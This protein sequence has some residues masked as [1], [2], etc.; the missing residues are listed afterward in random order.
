MTFFTKIISCLIGLFTLLNYLL[1][2]LGGRYWFML[3]GIFFFYLLPAIIVLILLQASYFIKAI[4]E[5]DYIK[6]KLIYLL[7]SILILTINIVIPSYPLFKIGFRNQMKNVLSQSQFHQ[8]AAVSRSVIQLNDH[9][10]GPGKDFWKKDTH[11]VQWKK[12]LSSTEIDKLDNSYV[13]FVCDSSVNI[14]W[15]GVL[16]HWGIKIYDKISPVN[17]NKMDVTNDIKTYFD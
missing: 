7:I 11:V 3:S 6:I 5:K 8:I 1:A 12:I 15:G 9:L 16:A 4:V 13:I 2:Y 10:P 17:H 14:I